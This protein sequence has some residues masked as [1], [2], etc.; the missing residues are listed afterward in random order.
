MSS[1]IL[2]EV[3][4]QWTNYHFRQHPPGVAPQEKLYDDSV[5]R[6]A[7]LTQVYNFPSLSWGSNGNFYTTHRSREIRNDLTISLG[8]HTWKA[9][10]DFQSLSFEGDNRP[11]IGTWTFRA[12]QPFDPTNLAAFVPVAGS[13]QQFT[14]SLLKLPRY[15]PNAMWSV[16]G[17]DEWRP[18]SNVTLTLGLRYDR[19]IRV[20]QRNAGLQQSKRLSHD[21]NQSGAPVR[22][23]GGTR[24]QGQLGSAGRPGVG[25]QRRPIGG[26]SRVRHLLQ[27][28]QHPDRR[29][30]GQQP[31]AGE[32]RDCQSVVSGSLRWPGPV[33]V[34]IDGAAEHHDPGQR[35]REPRVARRTRSVSRRSSGRRWPSMW[36][37]STPK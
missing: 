19:Q 7:P 36:T 23:P 5:A 29:P 6:T 8:Q 11:A 26:S 35:P 10:G 1:R 37:A 9:G 18:V 13:V 15:S 30:G 20:F 22:R 33:P 3:R 16:Y 34:R 4:G 31:A 25:S 32:R 21:G 27:P 24:R 28:E 17:Q 14:A 2:N 12:D